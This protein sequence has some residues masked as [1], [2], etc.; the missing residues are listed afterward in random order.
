MARIKLFALALLGLALVAGCGGGGSSQST[1]NAAN[2]DS[3]MKPAGSQS[4]APAT[5]KI[6]VFLGEWKVI[7]EASKVKAGKVVFNVTNGGA[8]THEMIVVRTSMP[9]AALTDGKGASEK[10][11]VGEVSE[12]EPRQTKTLSL[13]L[14]PGHYALICNESGH[15]MAGM[16]TDF[17][18][19]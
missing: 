3:T 19:E 13:H 14:K 9:A 4:T 18:V 7:P 8:V 15:Y 2:N 12:L 17:T 16:H 6:K 11:S 10:G 5:G 1:T